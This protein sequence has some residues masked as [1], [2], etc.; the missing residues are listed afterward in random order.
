MGEGEHTGRI[1]AGL[2]FRMLGPMTAQTPDGTPLALGP[3][4]QR[5]LLAVLLLRRGRAATMAELLGALWGERV[6]PRAVGTLRTYVSR[7]RTLFEPERAARAPARLLV[8]ASDGYALR[9]PAPVVD[10]EQFERGLAEAA[11]LRAAGATREAYRTL[12]DTLGLWAGTP[13]AGL[14]GPYAEIQRDRLTEAW[15]TAREDHFH[16]ALELGLDRDTA[17]V[18]ALRAFTAEHPLRER[19]QA[20]LMLALHRAGRSGDALAVYEATRE[21]LGRELGTTPG[22]ELVALHRRLRSR[23]GRPP[24]AG[25]HR[26]PAPP[27]PGAGAPAAAPCAPAA[28][29][30]GRAD[31]RARLVELLRGASGG[32]PVAVLTG[33]PGIG[34]TALATWAAGEAR[35]DFPDGVLR[36]ALGAGSAAPL[37]AL[38]QALGVPED[39]VPDGIEARAALYRSLLAGRR[40]LVLLDDVRD[41]AGLLPLLPG[42]PGCAALVTAAGRGL[43]VPGARL[44]DVPELEDAAALEL[45]GAVAGPRRVR[46]DPAGLR[47]LTGQCAGLPLALYLAGRRL[48]DEPDLTAAALASRSGTGVLT[49]LRGDG[50]A[51]EDGF[52]R[53]CESLPAGAVRALRATATA[54]GGFGPAEAAALLGICESEAAD[55][56]EELVDSGLLRPGTSGRYRYHPLVRAFVRHRLGS[57]PV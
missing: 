43:V 17:A 27:R 30:V 25:H 1:A 16:G 15:L 54:P 53:R 21:T 36:A 4:Q 34:K 26:E 9:L 55:T 31:E 56:I 40:V 46:E 38:V 13:L 35:P 29:F 10:I 18:A 51:V 32:V 28:P 41:T 2:R 50:R 22:P 37:A 23:A 45:L 52:R 11:R 47:E 57:G 6:P 33:M 42:T 7:L 44:L 20:L 19:A 48:R 3:N 24:D 12:D 49:R 8:S 5:A 14:C 39:Q